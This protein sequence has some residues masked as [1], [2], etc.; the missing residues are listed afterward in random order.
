MTKTKTMSK[1]RYEP[2]EVEF[3]HLGR[4][5]DFLESFSTTESSLKDW[6]TGDLLDSE[7]GNLS[8]GT[9]SELGNLSRGTDWGLGGSLNTD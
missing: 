2:P 8:R 5:L 4:P 6:D 9:D 3:F 7:L 1:V